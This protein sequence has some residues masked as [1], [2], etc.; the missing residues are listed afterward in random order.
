VPD[1]YNS[2]SDNLW[3]HIER[4]GIGYLRL[5]GGLVQWRLRSLLPLIRPDPTV[6]IV[7]LETINMEGNHL[8][9][10]KG[11]TVPGS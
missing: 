6:G 9:V 8:R 3:L 2:E 1:V 7:E 10:G 11:E 4:I 5:P